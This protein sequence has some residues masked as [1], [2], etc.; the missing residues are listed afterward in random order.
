MSDFFKA[1]P[2][3]RLAAY[4]IDLILLLA[5]TA[6]VSVW[7]GTA[8]DYSG[9]M[10][11]LQGV[12]T[13]YEQKYG[14][15]DLD[16]ITQEEYQALSQADKDKYEN[17]WTEM[18]EDPAARNTLNMIVLTRIIALGVGTL[19]GYLILEVLLPLVFKNGQTLG[20]KALGLCVMHKDHVRVGVMQVILR[21]VVGKYFVGTLIPLVLLMVPNFSIWI[22]SGSTIVAVIAMAQAF[23][24]LMS[25]ANC[26]I[27]DK[28]FHTV[29]ADFNQQYIFDTLEER[30]AYDAE[31][32]AREEAYES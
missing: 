17:A 32:E 24:V 30:R 21:A 13:D 8:M 4:L 31:L 23:I 11:A 15:K 28:L 1:P 29:V 6:G 12:Y 22:I 3:K 20:K 25:Q 16:S 14:I 10:D 26:G 19:L 27:H 2:I 9:Q 18:D 7:I 5:I